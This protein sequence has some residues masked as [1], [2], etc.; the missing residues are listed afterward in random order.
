MLES[1]I[2]SP[3]KH[4][5]SENT[6]RI[7]G[8]PNDAVS[9]F[10]GFL[11]ASRLVAIDYFI[12]YNFLIIDDFGVYCFLVPQKFNFCQLDPVDQFLRDRIVIESNSWCSLHTQFSTLICLLIKQEASFVYVINSK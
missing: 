3:R 12:R 6:I 10:I 4:R 7:L 9:V 1:I 8:V 2:D 5:S 11:Y